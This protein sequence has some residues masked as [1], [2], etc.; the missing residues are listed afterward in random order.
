[1]PGSGES[2]VFRVEPGP[3]AGS[4]RFRGSGRHGDRFL[5]FAQYD[6]PKLPAVLTDPVVEVLSCS[7]RAQTNWRVS[8]TEGQ[9]EFRAIAVQQIEECQAFYE[10]LHRRFRLSGSDRLAVRVLLWLLRLPGGAALLRRWHAH[11]H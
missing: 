5:D 7:D 8:C 10:P 2:I 4:I 3:A 1:M 9:F 11:R 6:G